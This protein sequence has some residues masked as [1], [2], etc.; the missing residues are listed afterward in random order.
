MQAWWGLRSRLALLV[1]AAL[2][3]VF[4]LLVYSTAQNRAAELELARNNLR[5]EVRLAAVYQQRLVDKVGQ[6]LRDMASGPSIRNTTIRLCVP[7]LQ[8]LRAQDPAY[9][10]LGVVGLNGRVTCQAVDPSGSVYLGDR[11]FFKQIVAGA[12]FAVGEYAVGRSSGRPGVGFGI[13][14][15]G[16]D[17]QLNGVAFAMLDISAIRQAVE[18]QPLLPG[19]QLRVLDRSARVLASRPAVPSA[20]GQP[21][22]D[23]VVVQAVRAKRQGLWQTPDAQGVEQ[24]YAVEPVGG[25]AGNQLFVAISVPRSALTASADQALR[26]DLIVLLAVTALGMACAWW[27]GGRLV[28]KPA[29]VIARQA[30]ALADGELSARIPANFAGAGELGA[31]AQT[32]NHMAESLQ[33]KR[34]ELENVLSHV[35]EEHS[36]L[37]LIINS[38]S[39]GLIAVD[40]EGR[41]LLCNEATERFYPAVPD[42]G[43]LSTWRQT[44]QLLR[45]DGKTPYPHEELPLSRALRGEQVSNWDV[46]LRVPGQRDR[47]LRMNAQPLRDPQG[48]L[49]G[50]LAV[51]GDITERKATEDFVMAQEQVLELIATGVA[52]PHSLEAVVRLIESAAPQSLCTVLLVEGGRL[53]HCAS[54]RMPAAFGHVINDMPIGP[55]AGACGTA[56]FRKKTVIVENIQ[57]DP[58]MKDYLAVAETYQLRACWSAPVLS[59]TGEVM[60]TF[61]I[62]HPEPCKPSARDMALLETAVRLAR[63]ALEK[64]HAEAALLGSEKRFRELAE[65]IEDVFYNRDI[66]GSRMAYVSPAYATIWGRSCE[67]LYAEP[68]SY[69]DSV[70]PDDRH[71]LEMA[72]EVNLRGEVSDAEYRVL[73]PDGSVRWVHDHTYPVLGSSGRIERVVGTAR[74]I[75]ERKLADLALARSKRALQ[76]LSECNRALT[77]MEEEPAL[78][79]EICRLA[80]EVGGYRMAWVGYAMDDEARSIQPMAHAGH[81]DGYL[82]ATPLSWAE[83]TPGGLGPAG[84]CI[85]TGQPKL[86]GDIASADNSFYSGAQALPRGYRSA[87]FL[88]LRNARRSFGLL[89]LYAAEPQQFA[90]EEVGLLQELADN[91][92]FGLAA[93]QSR[94][95]RA[96]IEAAVFKMAAGVSASGGDVFFQELAQNMTDALG[97]DAGFVARLLPGE[98]LR[99]RTVA[100]TVDGQPV[101]GF[102]YVVTDSPCAGLLTSDSV[103][104]TSDLACVAPNSLAV[105]SLNASAYA[106]Y[107]LKDAKGKPVGMVFVLFR[108]PLEK[109]SIMEYTMK[110]FASR[111]AA[112]LERLEVDNQ[113]RAQASLLDRAQDAI[114]VRQLD[115]TISYW[116]KGAERLYGW[117]AEEVIGKTMVT[118][119]YRDPRLLEATMAKTIA[120]NGDWS[121]ELE[122]RA[123]D[124][125]AVLVEARWTVVRNAEGQV[126]GVLG[127]NTDIRERHR[128]RDEILRLNASLEERVQKRTAQLEFANKQLEAYSYSVSHDLRTPLSAIDGFSNLLERTLEKTADDPVTQRGRHYLARI[129]AGVSQ[130][131]ELIDAMLALAQVSRSTLRW[132]EVDLSAIARDLLDG[133]QERQPR[134]G[135]VLQVTPG[136]VANGDPRLLKQVLENLLGNAWKF[137][138]KKDHT[139]ITFGQN[140]SV[141]GEKVFFVRDNGAGFDMTYYEKLFGPFQRLHGVSE[142]AGTGIGL[143]TVQ[144]IVARHGGRVWAEAAVDQGAT[145]YFTL[146][147]ATL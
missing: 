89:G 62:Y 34:A 2:L 92:A 76:M 37:E 113:L 139:E 83:L 82:A 17:G 136:L 135:A 48:Q 28:V 105:T 103:I 143:A 21:D 51:F 36:R 81:E 119:M 60:A 84:Q 123:R 133:Y 96:R 85:R 25:D 97:A 131:G 52:L 107:C 8:N 129:R 109:T 128:A 102:D 59:Q 86:S 132:E 69:I 13:S 24:V 43:L 9:A 112:E 111:A 33:T 101:A 40:L 35:G 38:M 65:N 95:E 137:S 100:G 23:A 55:E 115:R 26:F 70:H 106:G 79:G 46:M 98:P 14:V 108:K 127:I 68:R 63:I 104:I 22:S 42:D 66:H 12:K 77:R 144:R 7:Y 146:G 134:P 18:S 20:V 5:S 147:V 145:F 74:D 118:E 114:M 120:N 99:A 54:V 32:F 117:T 93:L 72:D 3:P 58:L 11:Y 88:P 121:G 78:L 41:F 19:A 125:K 47:I 45:L 67:S 61:A 87:I 116:N 30:D 44:H 50:G 90:D 73:R 49:V 124:G 56:A 53:R 138:G 57:T 75:T 15:Q 64:E 39:E 130:M 27:A 1:L 80:V 6:L 4:G 126:T 94:Q 16:D 91:L 29:R 31:I 10:N 141:D 142:F 110:V 71:L 140:L 122:Q